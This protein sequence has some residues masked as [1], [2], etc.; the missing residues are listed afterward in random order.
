MFIGEI[1]IHSFIQNVSV[2]RIS[3]GKY[4]PGETFQGGGLIIAHRQD[5]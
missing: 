4:S 5:S 1:K 3:T 2:G